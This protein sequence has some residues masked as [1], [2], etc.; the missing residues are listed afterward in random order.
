MTKPTIVFTPGAWHSP[1]CYAAVASLLQAAGY[2]H[3]PPSS[4][5][6]IAIADILPPRYPTIFVPLPSVDA[7][8]AVQSL[9]DDVK[10]IRKAIIGATSR[11]Q[12]VVVFCHSYSG[13]PASQAV[14]NLGKG[15]KDTVGKGG[16]V[17]LFYC[18][19][20]VLP[21]NTSLLDGLGGN[22][23]PWTRREV[24]SKYLLQTWRMKLTSSSRV[25]ICSR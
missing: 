25:T 14:E 2:V 24:S 1:V 8:I 7:P 17:L 22:H 21:I 9:D 3:Q 15:G 12:D 4:L 18:T 5:L 13:V 10:A 20:F 16:V 6:N 11:N 23:P 19:A